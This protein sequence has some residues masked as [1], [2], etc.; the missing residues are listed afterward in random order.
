MRLWHALMSWQNVPHRWARWMVLRVAL[1]LVRLDY[2]LFEVVQS[3][4]MPADLDLM[5][6]FNVAENS[7]VRLASTLEE[8]Q[9]DYLQPAI[10]TLWHVAQT[11]DVA[12]RREVSGGGR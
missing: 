10:K 12:L 6:R 9:A 3:L 11:S 7:S 5:R 1:R 4:P 2:L 8:V